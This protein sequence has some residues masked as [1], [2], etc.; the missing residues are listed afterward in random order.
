MNA[1]LRPWT[2][3]C[4]GL[5]QV[6]LQVTDQARA[7]VD[8]AQQQRLD[9]GPG[10]G[11]HAARGVVE[12]QVPQRRDM[13]DLE[14]ADLQTLQAIARCQGAVGCALGPCLAEHA[15]RLEV[16]PDGRVGRHGHC[17]VR[18][19]DA[20]IVEVQLHR[21]ARVLAVLRHQDGDDLGSR[22]GNWPHR[23]A[24]DCAA[25]PSDRRRAG[26]RSTSAPAWRHRSAH[27]GPIGMAP[28]LGRQCA[29]AR[30]ATARPRAVRPAAGR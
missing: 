4:G 8:D 14:A 10:A 19:R 23:R 11:E 20:Q 15:L 6:P 1:W 16:A 29:S 12:V 17:A 26:P 22:L 9:P 28:G 27:R 7:V 24:A 25:S 5:V 2:R 30:H 13:L 18:Q 21:P 3:L